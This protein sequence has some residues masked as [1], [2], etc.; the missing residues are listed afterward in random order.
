MLINTKLHGFYTAETVID[1]QN[2]NTFMHKHLPY[3]SVPEQWSYIA[4]IPLTANGKVN[5]NELRALTLRRNR[6][7][8]G[9]DMDESLPAMKHA[10]IDS[11]LALERPQSFKSD[12]ARDPEKGQIVISSKLSELSVSSEISSVLDPID[13]LPAK[14]GFHGQR[15][16]RHRLFILYRKFFSIVTLANVATACFILYRGIKENKYI[17]ADLATATA[18]NLCV[19]V[20]M[21]SEPVINLLFAVCCSVPT[22]WPLAIRRHC[23][24]VFHI[25]GIHSGCAIAATMWF[26]I[27]TVGA[28]LELAKPLEER[29]ISLAPTILSYLVVVIFLAI[30]ATSH[31]DFRAK[32][33]NLWEATHR[34][35]GWTC[36][37]LLWIQTFLAAADFNPT[38]TPSKAYLHSP[39]IYLLTLATL[40]IIFPWLL[41]RRVPVR[42]EPLS[43]HAIRLWFTHTTPTVGTS[44]RLASRPLLDWHGFATI[45]NPGPNPTGFSLI[46]SRAG[47]FTGRTISTPPT[48]VWIRGIPASGVLRIAPLFRSIVLV[49]TGSGIGPCLAVILAR[50]V[51]CRILWTAA[52]PEITFGKHI[53]DSVRRTDPNAIIHN[54]RTMGKPDM[55]LLAWRLY[56]ESGAEAV[57][58]ISNK[59]FTRSVV[60]DLEARGVPAYGAIFDS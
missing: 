3:Y 36:L 32:H 42:A 8:S 5:K 7:D 16:L 57:C 15:W 29:C 28:S 50:R 30:G 38:T 20:L 2:L 9:I 31:P 26:T 25:G 44:V 1:E 43:P 46:V 23:A 11:T 56:R 6:A 58:V 19:A 24:R 39:P 34:F 37:I 55:S 18:A 22:S 10:S 27:F 53:V 33:H 45:T 60:Y 47:D 40:A 12:V 17:L 54:T 52:N 51:P 13:T 35:G 14:N 49:A 21:R 59:R 41:L 48:H 4:S